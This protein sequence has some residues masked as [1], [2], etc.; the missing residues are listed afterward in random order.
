MSEIPLLL[1]LAFALILTLAW[2]QYQRQRHQEAL[3][4]ATPLRTILAEVKTKREFP[5]TR[6]RSREHEVVM[7][8]NMRFEAIFHPLHGGNDITLRLGKTE[9][10]RLDKGM[11]GML[12]VKGTRFVGFAPHQE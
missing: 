1:I 9:Y 2:R 7:M 12:Q 8:E 10:H 11:R 3:N 5:R 6:S 4:D